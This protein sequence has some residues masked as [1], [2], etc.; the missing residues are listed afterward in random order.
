MLS[1]MSSLQS[2]LPNLTFF[3]TPCIVYTVYGTR[4]NTHLLIIVFSS[5]LIRLR[6]QIH[7]FKGPGR[8][9]TG[10]SRWDDQPKDKQYL[11]LPVNTSI[12]A[13]A[14][15]A[16]TSAVKFSNLT[17]KQVDDLCASSQL[18]I[19]LVKKNVILFTASKIVNL[20]H[21]GINTL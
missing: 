16:A 21:D 3:G 1:I 17:S 5:C 7:N 15:S 12:P 13:T 4:S 20:L 10:C 14:I 9:K 2:L 8:S 18:I 6:S 11:S 19:R